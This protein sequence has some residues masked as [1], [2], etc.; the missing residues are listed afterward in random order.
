MGLSSM[1]QL[2][3][4]YERKARLFPGLLVALPLAMTVLF[5]VGSVEPLLKVALSLM[6]SCGMPFL[7]SSIA[8]DAGKRVEARLFIKWGGMPSTQLLRHSD[9]H[10]DAHTKRRYHETLASGI[11]VS[12]PSPEDELANPLAADE[13]YRAAGFWLRSQTKNTKEFPHVFRENI[14]YGFRRNATG[15]KHVGFFMAL[16]CLLALLAKPVFRALSTDNFL[17]VF[18]SGIGLLQ[19]VSIIVSAIFMIVWATCFSERSLRRAGHDYAD[20]LIRS[21]DDIKKP[22]KTRV[23][24]ATSA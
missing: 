1:E 20:R 22:R 11:K 8:R 2:F 18:I 17:E 10:F 21:C 13:S 4:P 12:L 16:F 7:L 3:D 6:V 23:V 24:P 19:T 9:G 14:A 15:L 5:L